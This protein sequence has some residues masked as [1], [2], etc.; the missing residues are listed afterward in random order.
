MIV[1]QRKG[2]NMTKS[3]R[4]CIINTLYD[5]EAW[6]RFLMEVMSR[7]SHEFHMV[8]L[9]DQRNREGSGGLVSPQSALI[10]LLLPLRAATPQ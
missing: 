8:L 7:L 3:K 6:L 9:V 2:G 10:L 4:Q 1:A 5:E